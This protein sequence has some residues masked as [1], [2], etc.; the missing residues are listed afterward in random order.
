MARDNHLKVVGSSTYSSEDAVSPPSFGANL[1]GSVE[2]VFDLS[3]WVGEIRTIQAEHN[4][5]DQKDRSMSTPSREEI[6]AKLMAIEARMDSRVASIEGKIDALLATLQGNEKLNTERWRTF[7]A[8]AAVL[9]ERDKRLTD[10]A[11]RAVKAAE[12]AE[13]AAQEARSLKLN[14]WASVVAQVAAVAAII[15]GAY[16]ANQASVIGIGQLIA[17]VAQQNAAPASST[18]VPR[19]P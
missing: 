9:D 6:D 8:R 3:H 2:K 1:E 16:F 15:V 7:D 19:K 14:F 4:Q 18:A 5:R 11:D 12:G 13:S 10:I 17:A